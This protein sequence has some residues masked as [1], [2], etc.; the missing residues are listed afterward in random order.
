MD[1]AACWVF[2]ESPYSFNLPI[3]AQGC[4]ID[5][6]RQYKNQQVCLYLPTL[7][8]M[9]NITNYKIILN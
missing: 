7:H 2:N 5:G 4:L 1:L 6:L 8:G 3:C 9:N